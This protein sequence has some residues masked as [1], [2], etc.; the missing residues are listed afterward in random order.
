MIMLASFAQDGD[1]V[2]GIWQS[3]HGSGRI[4]IYKDGN[5]YNGKLVWLKEANDESGR[6]KLD[7]N[8]PSKNL[9][10]QPINGLEVLRNFTY[11][12]DG[13][14]VDG[15][16]YDPKSGRT[17]SC[18]LLMSSSDKLEIRAYMGI[19][20]IGKTQVWSRVSE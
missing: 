16:V 4:Q 19:S 11:K 20:L 5:T 9:R 15:T 8:N 13:V 6:I 3:E 1:V 18:K 14:W 12:D 2:L 10:S 17:Y 7:I